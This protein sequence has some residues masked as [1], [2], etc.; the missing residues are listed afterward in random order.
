MKPY[1]VLMYYCDNDCKL[2]EA[3]GPKLVFSFC[4]TTAERE[5][6]IEHADELAD[7]DLDDLEVLVRPFV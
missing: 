6:L 7:V 1:E 5:F 3:W 4:Q 2:V